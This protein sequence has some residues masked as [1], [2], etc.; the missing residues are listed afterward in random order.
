[1]RR[2][3][4]PS[5]AAARPPVVHMSRHRIDMLWCAAPAPGPVPNLN[6]NP[7]TNTNPTPRGLRNG[8]FTDAA[9]FASFTN[10]LWVAAA[11]KHQRVESASLCQGRSRCAVSLS[12]SLSLERQTC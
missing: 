8:T 7:N 10:D 12:L 4:G 1:M 9:T 5:V 6:P 2:T 11:P 3:C